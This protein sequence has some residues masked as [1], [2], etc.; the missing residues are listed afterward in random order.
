MRF[1]LGVRRY[2]VVLLLEPLSTGD[3]FSTSAWPL[4]TTIVPTFFT[5]APVDEIVEA[6][7]DAA[8]AVPALTVPVLGDAMFGAKGTVAVSELERTPTLAA[9]HA[10]LVD[11]AEACGIRRETPEYWRE[12]YRPHLTIKKHG[13]VHEGELVHFVQVALVD[14]QPGQDRGERA[15]LA[16]IALA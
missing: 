15:V 8:S 12:G 11:A 1:T 14:M 5:D 4:H 6:L 16:A 3:R 10:A 2:V 9:A 7:T 13:R